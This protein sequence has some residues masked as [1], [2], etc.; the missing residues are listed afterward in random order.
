MQEWLFQKFDAWAVRT[1][2]KYAM[3]D[4]FGVINGFRYY[5]FYVEKHFDTSWKAKYLP[6][7]FVHKFTGNDYPNG[8]SQMEE[9]NEA[10]Y[11]PWATFSVVM[12]GGYT[13]EVNP[14]N[15]IK[16]LYAPAVSLRWADQSHKIIKMLPD[17]W[18]LFFHGIRRGSWA[19]APKKHKTVCESCMKHNNGVCAN[20][21]T[22]RIEFKPWM[23]IPDSSKER[24]GWK[25]TVWLKCD[26]DFDKLIETRKRAL[27]RKGIQR[28]NTKDEWH[29]MFLTETIK[30]RIAEKL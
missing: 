26:E 12:T 8:E 28:P 5:I 15:K 23:S 30:M 21:G 14:G 3:V 20:A 19:F 9:V 29:A 10:H 7:L 18:T 25:E 11:H 2:R 13:E 27:A 16:D 17:T 24:E 6:N 1:G 22:E 4:M